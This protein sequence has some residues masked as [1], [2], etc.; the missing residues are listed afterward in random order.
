MNKIYW[1]DAMNALKG[2][3]EDISTEEIDK[4]MKLQNKKSD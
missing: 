3:D 1:K 2:I 4:I